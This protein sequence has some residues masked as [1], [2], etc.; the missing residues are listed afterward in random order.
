MIA[1]MLEKYELLST[2]KKIKY[3]K[4]SM[5]IGYLTCWIYILIYSTTIENIDDFF[6]ILEIIF[7]KVNVRSSK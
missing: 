6:N 5:F 7:S 1:V 3:I 2:E 4:I